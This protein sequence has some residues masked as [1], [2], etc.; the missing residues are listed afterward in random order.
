MFQN[1]ESNVKTINNLM[2]S[3]YTSKRNDIQTGKETKDSLD[4]WWYL[5]LPAGMKAQFKELPGIDMNDSFEEATTN[6][7][8]RILEY[9]HFECTEQSSR[10]HKD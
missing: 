1:N 4:K 6:K 5:F 7:F 3:T 2:I 10:A 9:F 8:R